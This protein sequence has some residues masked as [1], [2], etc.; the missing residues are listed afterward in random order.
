MGEAGL[1]FA[2]GLRASSNSPIDVSAA[3]VKLVQQSAKAAM[4]KCSQA[5]QATKSSYETWVKAA[6]VR[7]KATDKAINAKLA[8]LEA[9]RRLTDAELASNNAKA[10][11]E[12]LHQ[13][14]QTCEA[15]FGNAEAARLA[16][17]THEMSLK[18]KRVEHRAALGAAKESLKST[19]AAEREAQ[20]GRA[21][22]LAHH[23]KCGRGRGGAKLAT[24]AA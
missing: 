24:G 20:T 5:W 8:H 12:Q 22:F 14:R 11:E 7:S 10:E 19:K 9:S 21:A 3:Q 1:V 4:R 23:S 6:C 18:Q 17:D 15:D 2:D 16:A 13:E